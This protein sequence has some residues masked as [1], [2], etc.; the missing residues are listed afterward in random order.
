MNIL[1]YGDWKIAVN[2]EKTKQYYANYKKNDN[3]ANLFAEH[4]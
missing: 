4:I 1:Q 3:Q 2:I